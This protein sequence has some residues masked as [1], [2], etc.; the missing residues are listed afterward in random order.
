MVLTLGFQGQLTRGHGASSPVRGSGYIVTLSR[1]PGYPP[2]MATV[3][4]TP[5]KTSA[6]AR[7][8]KTNTGSKSVKVA[9]NGGTRVGVTH[10]ASKRA[11]SNVKTAY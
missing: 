9:R 1:Q 7:F 8:V 5:T 11:H 4:R 3:K 6:S 2:G 10:C